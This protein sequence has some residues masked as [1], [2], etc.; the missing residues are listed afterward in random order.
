[1]CIFWKKNHTSL[2]GKLCLTVFMLCSIAR[3]S[4][5]SRQDLFTWVSILWSSKRI[6]GFWRLALYRTVFWLRST[7]RTSE[8]S[9][10]DR[11]GRVSSL[12]YSEKNSRFLH[13]ILCW[14]V[15]IFCPVERTPIFLRLVLCWLVFRICAGFWCLLNVGDYRY[16]AQT[17]VFRH[18]ICN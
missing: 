7:D 8:F 13:L 9:P 18:L 2:I 10:R 1:M 3:T 4:E 14:T 5:F 16:F 12:C 11:C 6:S 15:F 17:Y